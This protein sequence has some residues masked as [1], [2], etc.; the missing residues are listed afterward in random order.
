MLKK[1]HCVDCAVRDSLELDSLLPWESATECSA[2]APPS[3][4]LSC[5][6]LL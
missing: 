6:C 5:R 2:S 3:L 4:E 1:M